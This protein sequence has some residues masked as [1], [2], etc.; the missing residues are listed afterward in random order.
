MAEGPAKSKEITDLVKRLEGT[1]L[2]ANAVPDSTLSSQNTFINREGGDKSGKK[3]G[4]DSWKKQWQTQTLTQ[5]WI[6]C[7]FAE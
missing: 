6:A 4:G 2:C 1:Q 5:E 7:A 3:R